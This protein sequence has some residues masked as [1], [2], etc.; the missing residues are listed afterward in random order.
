M[1]GSPL[2]R[3]LRASSFNESVG[4]SFIVL[5]S[6]LMLIRFY[7]LLVH[8]KEKYLFVWIELALFYRPIGKLAM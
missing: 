5:A 4:D 7:S 8:P 3:S 1:T 6:R 2:S